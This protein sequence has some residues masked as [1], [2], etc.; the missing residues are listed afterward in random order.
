MVLQARAHPAATR[1]AVI[2]LVLPRGCAS[3]LTHRAIAERSDHVF[4]RRSRP[5]SFDSPTELDELGSVLGAATN[6]FGRELGRHF[7]S[8]RRARQSRSTAMPARL[9]SPPRGPRRQAHWHPLRLPQRYH[10]EAPPTV[11][12]RDRRRRGRPPYALAVEARAERFADRVRR[13]LRRLGAFLGRLRD[14]FRRAPRLGTRG[15]RRRRSMTSTTHSHTRGDGALIALVLATTAALAL[16][17]IGARRTTV[18]NPPRAKLEAVAVSH[19]LESRV[20]ELATAIATAEGYFAEG[21]HDGRTLPYL[22]NN[23]GAL[24]KPAL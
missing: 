4:F 18:V 21:G 10:R 24:K 23:P 13:Q 17:V 11:L 9:S 15:I 22:L 6:E 20:D 19:A 16:E 5:A 14:F 12:A 7:Y 1:R 2:A 3:L 8:R